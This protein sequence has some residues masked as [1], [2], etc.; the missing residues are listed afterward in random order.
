M[1]STDFSSH[2]QDL[3]EDELRARVGRGVGSGD[4]RAARK[5]TRLN[6]R[7]AQKLAR[8]AGPGAGAA[9]DRGPLGRLRAYGARG[10]FVRDPRGFAQRVVVKMHFSK[11]GPAAVA[12]GKLRA[13]TRYLGRGG[14]GA[15]GADAEFYNGEG[16]G[17][18]PSEMTQDWAS[19][20][21]HFRVI[22]SPENASEIDDLDAYTRVV[23]ARMEA[24]LETR[25]EWFGVNH[26]DTGQPHSHVVIR[27]RDE[28]GSD[29]VI[30]RDY[31]RSGLRNRAQEHA[32]ELLGERS[33]EQVR[34]AIR[35]EVEAE[36]VTSLDRSIEKRVLPDGILDL[37]AERGRKSQRHEEMLR[38]RMRHLERL[39]LAESEE[40]GI[41][42]LSK[43]W[44][45]DLRA[46]G[47]RDDIIKHLH[48][49][50]GDDWSRAEVY[51]GQAESP[52]TMKGR[53]VGKGYVDE[54]SDRR[55]LI[56]KS[57]GERATYVRMGAKGTLDPVKIG[58]IIEIGP[59]K[60][61]SGKAE[62]NIARIAE[63]NNGLYDPAVHAE[64][65]EK[66]PQKL[67]SEKLQEYI[68]AH[69]QRLETLAKAHIVEPRPD[70]RYKVPADVVER[71]Q[72]LGD[73]LHDAQIERRF[74]RMKVISERPV[75][76]QVELKEATWLDSELLR[77]DSGK[78]ATFAHDRGT[79]K[80][81][82]E[83]RAWLAENGFA[84]RKE[85][86]VRVTEGTLKT[87]DEA[88]LQR[89]SR[90]YGKPIAPIQGVGVEYEGTYRGMVRLHSGRHAVIERGNEIMVIRQERPLRIEIGKRVSF[91]LQKS[92]R[93]LLGLARGFGLG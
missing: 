35:Q 49:T 85:G 3:R 53:V 6:V 32:T 71:A 55:Y 19:D 61:A 77:V 89:L 18:D 90:R 72:A 50:L 23:M 24:D 81:L 25:L 44:Q 83:R 12:A 38:G 42:R 51:D 92:G 22:I 2:F 37:R 45:M 67:S 54:L 86:R 65:V 52:K 9:G 17:L 79:A 47:E 31:I 14:V 84:E 33:V 59:G 70:G 69:V 66:R 60:P 46:L 7:L 30:N 64:M 62:H 74:V 1:Q 75:Q 39:G 68:G 20:R 82:S 13:H 76:R 15:D 93:V 36:R 10:G 21:H 41:W 28:A 48:R 29:L 91:Q 78:A 80:A 27:G 87:L 4:R 63:A 16:R 8:R 40:P 57:E 73:K 56:L 11:H 5:T 43:R 26:F 88:H 34:E 58:S